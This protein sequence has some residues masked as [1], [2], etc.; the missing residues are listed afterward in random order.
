MRINRLHFCGLGNTWVMQKPTTQ[1]IRKPIVNNRFT[2]GYS[3]YSYLGWESNPHS[4]GNWILNPARLPVPPP[5][6]GDLLI[7]SGHKNNK[8]F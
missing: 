7:K 1:K 2:K 5:R 8:I 4:R 6:Q 3:G